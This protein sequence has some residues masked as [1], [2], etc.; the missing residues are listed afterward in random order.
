MGRDPFISNENVDFILVLPS[1]HWEVLWLP[2]WQMVLFFQELQP[3][4]WKKENY[5]PMLQSGF[6]DSADPM[7]F[8]PRLPS[9][10]WELN[11]QFAFVNH[12]STST[13]SPGTQRTPPVIVLFLHNSML[14]LPLMKVLLAW[15][16][17]RQ[18]PLCVFILK[19][20][21][22][23]KAVCCPSPLRLFFTFFSFC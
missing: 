7:R 4:I 2:L 19:C 8:L 15:C 16:K 22:M 5:Y 10:L 14:L 17:N 11:P 3:N 21:G 1:F 20:T 9:K 13:A 18:Q 23:G 6:L 12:S